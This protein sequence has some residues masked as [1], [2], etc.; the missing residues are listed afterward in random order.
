MEL[1]GRFYGRYVTLD[2]SLFRH[3]N[4][5]PNI[6]QVY[7]VGIISLSLVFLCSPEHFYRFD[8]FQMNLTALN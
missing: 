6:C 5:N 2:R 1:M 7:T 3:A 8:I 4:I